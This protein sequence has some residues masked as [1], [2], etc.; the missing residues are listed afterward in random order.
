MKTNVYSNNSR[1]NKKGMWSHFGA[2]N[3]K[4]RS[5]RVGEQLMNA[6]GPVT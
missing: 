4:K 6:E 1:N 5:E 3:E 2:E